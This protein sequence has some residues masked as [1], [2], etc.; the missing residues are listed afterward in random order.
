M[1][2]GRC[3]RPARPHRMTAMATT[4]S[5]AE[6]SS[7]ADI[8]TLSD[9]TTWS[10]DQP[11]GHLANKLYAD[12]KGTAYTYTPDDRLVTRAWARGIATTY[13]CDDA[14]ALAALAYSDDTPGVT[15]QHDRLGRMA[16]AVSAGDQPVTYDALDPVAKAQPSKNL[17][18][19]TQSACLQGVVRVRLA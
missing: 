19:S 3:R 16:F 10:C 4:R 2:D 7:A 13:A 17:K 9:R 11:T 8:F 18:H 6:I 5:P 14:G 15:F 1:L 12:G